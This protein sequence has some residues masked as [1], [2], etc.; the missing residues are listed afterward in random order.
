MSRQKGSILCHL[1]NAQ[2]S[3]IGQPVETQGDFFCCLAG[4]SA[5]TRL[6]FVHWIGCINTIKDYILGTVYH[7][8]SLFTKFSVVTFQ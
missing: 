1:A 5:P 3:G 8:L 7:G 2:H 4:W 6:A